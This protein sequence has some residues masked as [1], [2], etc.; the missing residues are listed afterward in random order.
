MVSLLIALLLPVI[1]RARS[2]AWRVA[3]ASNE[4]QIAI[5]FL[6][7]EQD[8][9]AYAS[10]VGWPNVLLRGSAGW[11]GQGWDIRPGLENYTSGHIF[12][13]PDGSWTMNNGEQVSTAFQLGG[14]YNPHPPG[15]NVVWGPAVWCNYS[16]IPG[17]T[18]RETRLPSASPPFENEHGPVESNEDVLVPADAPL[19]T[20]MVFGTPIGVIRL[21]NHPYHN[22][23][24]TG[25]FEGQNTVFFDGHA[26]WRTTDQVLDLWY[27]H[28]HWLWTY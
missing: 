2:V 6:L 21:Q 8:H 26:T 19:A 13:C 3:C 27:E 15:S 24:I 1:T 16:L 17:M 23:A 4:R 11:W 22:A 28:A 12:Y 5:A 18:A 9:H 7:Y 20:D 14:W 25:P 10:R